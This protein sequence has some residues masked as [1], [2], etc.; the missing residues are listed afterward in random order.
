MKYIHSS[1]LYGPMGQSSPLK[2]RLELAI[3]K[4]GGAQADVIKET[5]TRLEAALGHFP[6]LKQR[7]D[8]FEKLA[9]ESRR[10]SPAPALSQPTTKTARG[11]SA[12]EIG[13]ELCD[14]YQTLNSDEE[15]RAFWQ[16]NEKLLSDAKAK[17]PGLAQICMMAAKPLSPRAQSQLPMNRSAFE[18]LSPIERR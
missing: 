5:E 17:V 9:S 8:A 1:E 2:D 4:L 12:A 15:R 6:T 16:S 7:V 14:K 10:S 13:A 18:K 11:K 3:S